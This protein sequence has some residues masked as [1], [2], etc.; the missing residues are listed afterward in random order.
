MKK[1]FYILLPVLIVLLAGCSRSAA[2]TKETEPTSKIE[3]ITH[4]YVIPE[5]A[6][7]PGDVPTFA[8]TYNNYP[9]DKRPQETEASYDVIYYYIG[10]N[11]MGQ[12]IDS[13]KGST[14]SAED[15][16]DV[17]VR[18]AVL[19]DGVKVV[20]YTQNGDVEADLE[21]DGVE[22]FYEGATEEE[23]VQAIANTICEN[24]GVEKVTIKVGDK[25]YGPLVLEY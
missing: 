6:K 20:S 18:G 22:P 21:L 8:D 24:L 14:C 9:E 15:L 19:R 7:G 1:L 2:G 5:D 3:L 13:I 4:E 11:G 12:D 23:V 17:L 16:M 25:T 10:A